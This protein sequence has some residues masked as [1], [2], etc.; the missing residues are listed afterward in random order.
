MRSDTI[1]PV[2][3]AIDW[4]TIPVLPID[5]PHWGTETDIRAQ[6]QICYDS[7]ALYLKMA[8]QEANIRAE[9]EGPLSSPCRDSCLEFFFSPMDGD[10][11]YFNIEFSPTGAVYLGFGGSFGL[12]RLIRETN[13]LEPVIARTEDG[14]EITYRVPFTMIRQFFPEFKAEPGK[15]IR[16]NFYKCGDRTVNK[17]YLTWNAITGPKMSYHQPE[18]F[19]PLYFG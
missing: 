8:A 16:A 1:T 5:I 12:F 2:C 3:G 10:S 7:E 13:P 17:H 19:A 18:F 9:E 14:W 15:C 6:A 4:N 11:R